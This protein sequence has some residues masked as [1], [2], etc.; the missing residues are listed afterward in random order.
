VL[1][2]VNGTHMSFKKIY[3]GEHYKKIEDVINR[4]L[5][6]NAYLRLSS[7]SFA[8]DRENYIGLKYEE[9]LLT[10]SIKS[11]VELL[12][13]AEEPIQIL[14]ASST[15]WQTDESKIETLFN[16]AV[17]G[18][19]IKAEFLDFKNCF[20]YTGFS[21]KKVIWLRGGAEL[22]FLF[23]CLMEH[24]IIPDRTDYAQIIVSNFCRKNGASFK[25]NSLKTYMWRGVCSYVRANSIEKLIKEL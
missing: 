25:N 8:D 15:G 6:S 3:L 18:A 20:I 7:K 2:N 24:K 23:K 16:R 9:G 13:K 14:E 22:V 10:D 19:F 17:A 21:S 11:C 12:V 4:F 1:T 5:Q